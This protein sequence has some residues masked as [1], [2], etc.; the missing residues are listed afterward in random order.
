MSG[1]GIICKDNGPFISFHHAPLTADISNNNRQCLYHCQYT[2]SPVQLAHCLIHMS[3]LLILHNI[4]RCM[5]HC[6]LRS[7]RL[8]PLPCNTTGWRRS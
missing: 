3:N 2:P 6:S 1:G 7:Q 8:W 4:G 5:G